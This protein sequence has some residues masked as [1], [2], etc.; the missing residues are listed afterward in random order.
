VWKLLQA[1]AAVLGV[2]ALLFSACEKYTAL[3]P[4]RKASKKSRVHVHCDGSSTTQNPKQ[5]TVLFDYDQSQGTV[6]LC[7]IMLSCYTAP[8]CQK[9][10]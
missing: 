5:L 9:R 2:A 4:S 8:Y 6:T 10:G 3:K 1:I 7:L